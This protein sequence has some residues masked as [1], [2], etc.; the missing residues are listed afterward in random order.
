VIGDP[1]KRS[2]D[3]TEPRSVLRI[4][5]T[6]LVLYGRYPLL[7][8]SLALAVI[9]PYELIVLAVTKAAPFGEQ[10]LSASTVVIL[11]LVENA[12]IGPLISALVVTALVTVAE[13]GQPKLVDVVT[14]GV[15]VLPVVAAAQIVAG[16]GILIG[17]SLF[18]IPGVL[19]AIRLAVVAQAAAVER[20][21]W[22][23]AL[24]RSTEL[25]AR[26]WLHVFGVIAIAAIVVLAVTDAGA[27]LAGTGNHPAQVAIGIAVQ[28][29]A[30][31]FTAIVMALLYF[32]L[33]ARSRVPP[34][35]QTG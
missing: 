35:G 18:V 3:M 17:L 8:L 2:V 25:T 23:G 20:T 27:A 19:V 33:L 9:A 1:P 14:R 34:A 32:D 7:I 6:S 31:S 11:I 12:L 29:V 10:S 4:I 16:I 22:I 5:G 15:T 30:R 28:T 13:G 24:R 21:D 26:Q